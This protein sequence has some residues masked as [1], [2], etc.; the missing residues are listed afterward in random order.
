MPLSNKKIIVYILSVLLLAIVL[1][2]AQVF[3]FSPASILG[4]DKEQRLKVI[5][6]DVGQGSA[7]FVEA[8]NSNQALIDGGPGSQILGKLGG[9]MP[10]FDRSIDIIILTH[11]DADHINGLVEVLEKYD[12]GGII[13][14]CIDD[15]SAAYSRW[16]KLIEKKKI[17]RFCA[18]SGKK[19]R[20]AGNTE[21]NILYPF[22][23][24]AGRSF[25]N[26]NDSSV[27]AKIV[28]GESSILL[29]GDAEEK[30]EYQL[31]NSGDNLKSQV[32]QVGHHGSKSSTSDSFLKSV[33]PETAVIQV[34]AQNRYGHPAQ[35]VLSRLKNI[36]AEVFRTDTDGDI[37]FL[38][39]RERC[40]LS[41]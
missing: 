26:T 2:W 9:V 1:I 39:N 23:P 28:Y 4:V 12:A 6:F 19:I 20:L 11:P 16:K 10:F 35:E 33:S 7:V 15:S 8:S 18:V 14:P 38:C 21:I 22:S 36:R 37:S 34:G 32:M 41:K 13:D 3:D 5:F 27:V 17:K 40:D 30:T 24:L 25:K 29:T 31:V